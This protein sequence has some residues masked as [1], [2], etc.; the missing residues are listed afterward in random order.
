MGEQPGLERRVAPRLAVE[1]DRPRRAVQHLHPHRA[2]APEPQPPCPPP[3]ARPAPQLEER[4]QA[5]ERPVRPQ[6]QHVEPAVVGGDVVPQ[7]R[8]GGI[9]SPQFATKTM[10][11]GSSRVTPSTVTRCSGLVTRGGAANARATYAAI[12][13]RHFSWEPVAAISAASKPVPQHTAK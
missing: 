5:L 1:L 13:Q 6:R 7:L 9:S 4:R 3:V 12:F 10:A 11:A 2:A 8:K